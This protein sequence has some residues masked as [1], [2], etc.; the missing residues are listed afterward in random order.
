MIMNKQEI[1]VRISTIK[2]CINS[3]QC[4]LERLDELLKECDEVK[5]VFPVKG[6]Y[7]LH[8]DGFCNDDDNTYKY[9][10]YGNTFYTSSEVEKETIRRAAEVRV[11]EKINIANSGNGGFKHGG[12]NIEIFYNFPKS[13]LCLRICSINQ[14]VY[15]WLY[16]MHLSFAVKLLEDLEFCKDYKLM[17]GI[18]DE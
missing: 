6:C 4:E 14:T 8:G 15:S 12:D 1:E 16:V 18:N 11:R 17:L 7:C 3:N 9:A 5:P 2:S 13:K 10:P